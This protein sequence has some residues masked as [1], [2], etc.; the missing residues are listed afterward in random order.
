MKFTMLKK[1]LMTAVF[2]GLPVAGIT[3]PT[4]A[5]AADA[6][7]TAF[8]H[9]FEWSWPD[10]AQE[11]EDVLGPNGFA[12]V[13]VSPPQEGIA[14]KQWW[15]RYQVMSYELN[16]RSGDRAQFADMVTR[17]KNA[18]VDI[19]V[20]AVVNHMAA[21][22]RHYP[23]VP[24]Y[25]EHFH[26]C[27]E[28]INYG[29][30]WSIQTCGLSGLNDLDTGQPYVQQKIADYMNDLISLGVAGFRLDAAKH[31]AANE[32]AQ[33][34]SRVN[35]SPYIFQEVIGA[36]GEPVKPSEYTG[37][38]DVT[39]FNYEK[40]MTHYFRDGG[41]VKDLRPLNTWNDWLPSD[42]AVV[43][44]ANHD[45]QRQHPEYTLT[46]NDEEGLYYLAHIFMLA[47]PYGYP[48]VMSSYYFDDHDQGPPSS[49][50]HTG[51]AC[52][53][54][55]VCEHRWHG[56]LNMVSFRNHTAA[57]WSVDNWW[58]NGQNQIAFSRGDSGFVV[59]NR[60]YQTLAR[61][62]QTGLAA[63][64]YCN[65]IADDF[66]NGNCSGTA[67]T[68]DSNGYADISVSSMN[69]AA[70]HV[71]SKL[72]QGSACTPDDNDDND[73]GNENEPPANWDTAFFR[74]TPN[75]WSTTSMTL[76]N[77]IWQTTQTFAA[78]NPRFKIDHFGN[79]TEAYPAQDFAITEGAGTYD[80]TFNDFTQEITV[81]KQVAAERNVTFTCEN[82]YTYWG[83][84]VYIVGNLVELGNWN[85]ANAIKLNATNY[86]TWSTTVTL[87][88]D[89]A[90]Q[91]KCIKRAENN[92]NSGL[93]W[94]NGNDNQL[95]AN[96]TQSTAGF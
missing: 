85:P 88:T 79:W 8:V 93:E 10:I 9:L 68:V 90:A 31:I 56:M 29:D 37:N 55:W 51:N 24:Y 16:S 21:G 49:G 74:G 13:Q 67:I 6:P 95:G 33:I 22:L 34:L 18:G 60:E 3:L 35:G 26:T 63:G 59:I 46:F 71:G 42:S 72:C 28:P 81:T 11:C 50:V 2:I 4:M 19:Y 76:V 91:W 61:R 52:N 73:S 17:C 89:T 87:P 66:V 83:Q 69:A 32:I 20:D 43:F 92:A 80:I 5:H 25:E 70:I 94:Q 48:K 44:V 45:D 27:F 58:D 47:Y 23:K 64:E 65:I 15:T 36:G 53:Q 1:S 38:G 62:F 14:G 77:G 41:N 40:T 30:R 75:G 86:P 82:G 78:N 12:A 84:S 96:A 7:R 57:N 39:E 54:G